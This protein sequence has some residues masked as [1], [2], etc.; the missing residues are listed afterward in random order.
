MRSKVLARLITATAAIA[1]GASAGQSAVTLNMTS[2]TSVWGTSAKTADIT[3]TVPNPD[4]VYNNLRVNPFK[5]SGTLNDNGTIT[6]LTNKLSWCVDLFQ[7]IHSGSYGVYSVQDYLALNLNG[8]QV[9]SAQNVLATKAKYI[10]AL[11]SNVGRTS[12]SAST[13]AAVQLALWELIYEKS[14]TTA[15]FGTDLFRA[16]DISSTTLALAKSY[17]DHA[18]TD[19]TPATDIQIRIAKSSSYQDQLFFTPL[20]PPPIPEPGTWAMMIIGFG[21]VGHAMRARRKTQTVA[22][23]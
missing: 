10:S 5:F 1:F 19:W 6:N 23:S 4:L 15:N 9:V 22:F 14:A 2:I 3:Y 7:T 21:A 18:R 20:P 16:T 13:D 12:V 8:S 17:A 11:I